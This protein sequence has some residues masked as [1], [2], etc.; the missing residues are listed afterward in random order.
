VAIRT[1]EQYLAGLRD[2]RRVH[3]KGR[4]LDDVLAARD[5]SRAAERSAIAYDLQHDPAHRQLAVDVTD[6]DE[7]SAMFCLPKSPSDLH[8]RAALIE[9]ASTKGGCLILLKEVGTDALFALLSALDGDELKR[10]TAYYETCRQ[11][12]V[13]IAVAQTDVKGDRSLPPHGQADP[14]LYVHVVDE[15]ADH[16][17][18]RGAKAHTT[19]APYAD[20]LLVLPTRAMTP[21]DRDYAVSFA[22]PIDTPGLHLYA[23]PY[24]SGE[25]NEFEHPVSSRVSLIETLTVFDDVVV[26]KDRVFLDRTPELAGPLALTFANYH[27]FSAV[28]YKLPMVDLIVGA[29]YLVVEANGIGRAGHVRDKLSQLVRWAETVRGLAHVAALRSERDAAG[30]QLPSALE[31][32]MAKFEF[33]HGY[34]AAVATLHDLAGGM[35]V[36]GPGGDDWNDPQT[37]AV[38]EKYYAAAVPG[39]QRLR[40]LHLI[41]DLTA[42]DYGGYQAV[43][44][45]HAEGSLEAEKQQLLRSYSPDRAVALARSV[46]GLAS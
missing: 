19:F 8:R 3:Y 39:E 40:V 20:E 41:A 46:A 26:P 4:L 9:L 29:A 12:D 44:A 7:T 23:S 31:V 11:R 17:V 28:M 15:D 35:L 25:R 27:R 18:V 24:L 13:A 32:N 43:I 22:I 2:G 34:P 33:A 38:L 14:D 21:D 5:L 37:R 10:A 1:R 42:R 6:G 45:A 16:I 36:T 30:M